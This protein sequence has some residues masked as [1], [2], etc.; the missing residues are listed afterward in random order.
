MQRGSVLEIVVPVN[1]LKNIFSSYRLNMGVVGQNIDYVQDQF[2]MHLAETGRTKKN[3]PTTQWL[4]DHLHE[5]S[6]DFV[7][8]VGNRALESYSVDAYAFEDRH[9]KYISSK[10]LYS[11]HYA[12][13]RFD[14]D[15]IIWGFP[16]PFIEPRFVDFGDKCFRNGSSRDILNHPSERDADEVQNSRIPLKKVR[17]MLENGL[18]LEALCILNGYLQVNF[19]RAIARAILNVDQQVFNFCWKLPYKRRLELMKKM[20]NQGYIQDPKGYVANAFLIDAFRNGY[21]HSLT[22]PE[23]L[24]FLTNVMRMKIEKL[25]YP[26]L[27]SYENHQ[28]EIFLDTFRVTAEV[29]MCC[30]EEYERCC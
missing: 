3:G 30:R 13:R 1:R 5:Y 26:F 9:L 28:F 10:D 6:E 19:R 24:L 20:I 15:S 23:N 14:D 22:V 2:E 21:L 18:T 29:E 11:R 17:I 12:I 16:V 25:M 4:I 8:D 27:D 7:R